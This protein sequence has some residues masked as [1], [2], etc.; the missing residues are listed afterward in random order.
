VENFILW[1]TTASS[2]LTPPP[3]RFASLAPMGRDHVL[4][5]AGLGDHAA[6]ADQHDV[7]GA[8]TNLQLVDLGR[9]GF[10]VGGVGSEGP[11]AQKRTRR[12]TLRG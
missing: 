12:T 8:E 2:G 1:T 11:F 3:A 10:G 9:K 6:I 4:A 7:S 5:D